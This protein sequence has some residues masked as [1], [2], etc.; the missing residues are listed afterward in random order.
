MLAKRS[1]DWPAFALPDHNGAMTARDVV[2]APAGVE[3][4]RAWTGVWTAYREA[5]PSVAALARTHGLDAWT[6]D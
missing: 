5:A 4:D 1:R 2:A 6:A 3:R